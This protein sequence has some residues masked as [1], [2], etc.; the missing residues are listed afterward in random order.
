MRSARRSASPIATTVKPLRLGVHPALQLTYPASG[1]SAYPALWNSGQQ[2]QK[3]CYRSSPRDL[4]APRARRGASAAE[5]CRQTDVLS[6]VRKNRNSSVGLYR[7]RRRSAHDRRRANAIRFLMSTLLALSAPQSIHA[8]QQNSLSGCAWAMLMSSCRPP[9]MAPAIR[10]YWR[11][12]NYSARTF[13]TSSTLLS[14]SYRYGN[15]LPCSLLCCCFHPIAHGT[16][17]MR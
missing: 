7:R 5:P 13:G 2:S 10:G 12:N 15:T 9:S 11:A 3:T 17:P 16:F 14:Q 6:V 1:T 8:F 4:Q